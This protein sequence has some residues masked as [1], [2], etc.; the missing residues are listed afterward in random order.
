MDPLGWGKTELARALAEFLFDDE[1]SMVRIDMSEYMEKHAVARLIGAPP[2]YVGYEEGGQLTEAIRRRPYSVIL[3]DEIEKAHYDVFNIL[4]QIL[5]DGRLTDS[6]GR[7]VDFRNA[8]IL[9]TSNLGST[10]IMEQAQNKVDFQSIRQSVLAELKGHF[11][12]EFLNRIDDTIVFHPLQ[13]EDLLEIV[14]IQLKRLQKRLDERR[15]E[16]EMSPD[17]MKLLSET[18]F[19]P[20]YGAS[21]ERAIQKE[22]GDSFGKGAS[23]RNCQRWAETPMFN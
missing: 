3:F 18:G 13:Q 22:L 23:L 17:A 20:L 16:L 21:A 15:I 14:Q 8:L 7:T 10:R 11:R 4:L 5:E 9:M 12:P 19:D 1:Q 6:Q 2:G